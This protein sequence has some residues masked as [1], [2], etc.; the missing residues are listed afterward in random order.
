MGPQDG[1]KFAMTPIPFARRMRPV[2]TAA[3][4]VL[5][6]WPLLGLPVQAAEERQTLQERRLGVIK[7]TAPGIVILDFEPARSIAAASAA[8]TPAQRRPAHDT[9]TAA[10]A[11]AASA[12]P[13]PTWAARWFNALPPPSGRPLHEARR[14]AAPDQGVVVPTAATA[15]APSRP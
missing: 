4:L 9:T 15:S 12:V 8:S 13:K 10:P 11:A 2:P 6:A 14:L 5:L 7:G 3:A 1:I